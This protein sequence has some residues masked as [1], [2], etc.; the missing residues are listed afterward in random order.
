MG[1]L[2][3]TTA[4]TEGSNPERT[5]KPSLLLCY[6]SSATYYEELSYKLSKLIYQLYAFTFENQL[7]FHFEI[8]LSC[9]RYKMTFAVKIVRQHLKNNSNWQ[10]SLK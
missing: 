6:L 7:E 5:F 1:I 3:S 9:D 10:T 4:L 8:L 2:A